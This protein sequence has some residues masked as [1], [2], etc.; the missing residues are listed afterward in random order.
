MVGELDEEHFHDVLRDPK[1]IDREVEA[2]MRGEDLDE[3]P[4][5]FTRERTPAIVTP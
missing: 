4:S 2:A 5:R 1:M 3:R